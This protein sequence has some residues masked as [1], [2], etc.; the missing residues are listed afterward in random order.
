MTQD[1][2]PTGIEYIHVVQD[3]ESGATGDITLSPPVGAFLNKVAYFTFASG[4]AAVL[5]GL[6]RVPNDQAVKLASDS[7]IMIKE[8]VIPD[9]RRIELKGNFGRVTASPSMKR[10]NI[11]VISKVLLNLAQACVDLGHDPPYHRSAPD[12][13]LPLDPMDSGAPLGVRDV[14]FTVRHDAV[15]R[16]C[17][18]HG[19]PISLAP[20]LAESFYSGP[21]DPASLH[22]LARAGLVNDGPMVSIAV[23]LSQEEWGSAVY[24]PGKWLASRVADQLIPLVSDF[25]I[26]GNIRLF[27]SRGFEAL[28]PYMTNL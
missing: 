22:L 3:L 23:R 28:G 12:L 1:E 8:W 9:W 26:R 16:I 4:R 13:V 5:Y 18:S 21:G 7:R 6:I 15:L 27:S 2:D 25:V 10:W 19:L 17:L 14:R 20:W 11:D 24:D